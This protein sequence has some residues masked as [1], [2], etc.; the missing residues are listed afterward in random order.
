VDI[1]T[2]PPK[3]Y[4]IPEIQSTELKEVNKLKSP[5]EDTSILFG[6]EKKAI[7]GGE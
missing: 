4:R 7:T 1:S 2:P 5:S 6:R 3:K